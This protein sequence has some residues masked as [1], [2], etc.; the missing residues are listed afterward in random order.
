MSLC[1]KIILSVWVLL[2][3]CAFEAFADRPVT[4]DSR[5]KVFVYNEYEV[6]ALTF[7]Y[8]HH[9]HIDFGK[10]EVIKSITLGYG[11]GWDINPSGSRLFVKPNERNLHT[12]MTVITNKRSYE[13]DIFSRDPDEQEAADEDLVYVAKFYYPDSDEMMRGA[14]SVM[15]G[16]Q[17]SEGALGPVSKGSAGSINSQSRSPGSNGAPL[18]RMYSYVGS[19]ELAPREVFDDGL[20]TYMKF[21]KGHKMPK[22]VHYVDA[23]SKEIPLDVYDYKGYAVVMSVAPKFILKYGGKKVVYLFNEN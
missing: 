3:C 17:S 4:V 6:F 10:G 7:H 14:V 15:A 19:R 12:N 16:G 11:V 8:G 2:Q 21:P 5:I 18:N 20:A 9:G 22:S 23:N 13:F 1:N